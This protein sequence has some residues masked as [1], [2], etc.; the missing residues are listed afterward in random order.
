MTFW[1]HHHDSVSSNVLS[2]T[3]SQGTTIY[4]CVH[5][6]VE[7]H[8]L[9]LGEVAVLAGGCVECRFLTDKDYLRKVEGQPLHI[10]WWLQSPVVDAQPL[11]HCG[12]AKV[13]A[14]GGWETA[15][16]CLL[17]PSFVALSV[18]ASL[19]Q[20]SI[21]LFSAVSI[22]DWLE[23]RF[24]S[25]RKFWNMNL[26]RTKFDCPEVTLCGWQDVKIQLTS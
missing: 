25:L 1:K 2:I 5:V 21:W 4:S 16:S 10:S 17:R 11:L 9:T 24:I 15:H 13:W 22:V 19:S 8:Q 14:E 12:Q 3:F 7:F 23:E 6:L 20:T 26:R 18:Y